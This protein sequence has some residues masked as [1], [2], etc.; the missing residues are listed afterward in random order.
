MSLNLELMKRW[1]GVGVV[2]FPSNVIKPGSQ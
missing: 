1:L 2:S